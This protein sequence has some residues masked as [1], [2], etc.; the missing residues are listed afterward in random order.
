MDI[1]WKEMTHRFKKWQPWLMYS[2]TVQKCWTKTSVFNKNAQKL[3]I[4]LV[5]KKKKK[6]TLNFTQIQNRLC[7][8]CRKIINREF[9]QSGSSLS[10]KFRKCLPLPVSFCNPSKLWYTKNNRNLDINPNFKKPNEDY[11]LNFD[12]KF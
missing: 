3:L 8:F 1:I 7:T 12:M 4:K 10:S 2:N 9:V 11:R 5:S 6:K